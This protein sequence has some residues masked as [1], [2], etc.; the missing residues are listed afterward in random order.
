MYQTIV[1]KS[2]T[3]RGTRGGP[4]RKGIEYAVVDSVYM[5]KAYVSRSRRAAK[6]VTGILNNDRIEVA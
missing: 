6:A 2:Q 4:V 3:P 5:N 1:T